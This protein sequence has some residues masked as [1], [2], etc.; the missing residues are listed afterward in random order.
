[1]S[2][3]K[4]PS[5]CVIGMLYIKCLRVRIVSCL[6]SYQKMIGK[7]RLSVSAIL[8]FRTVLTFSVES[9][10]S[11]LLFFAIFLTNLREN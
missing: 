1:M 4:W 3:V 2:V 8:R 10:I 11:S 5:L 7:N 9:S 6:L